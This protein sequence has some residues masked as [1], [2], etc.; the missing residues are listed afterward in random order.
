MNLSRGKALP[1]KRPGDPADCISATYRSDDGCDIDK[2][3]L[4]VSYFF[5]LF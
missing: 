3:R 5:S 2:N 4:I 1:K